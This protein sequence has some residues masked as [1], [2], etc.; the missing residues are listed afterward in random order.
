MHGIDKAEKHDWHRGKSHDYPRESQGDKEIG[1]TYICHTIDLS[2][3]K[4]NVCAE[5]IFTG[6]SLKLTPSFQAEW[7]V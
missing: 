4:R 3:A 5:M 7:E 2:A 1:R 6:L